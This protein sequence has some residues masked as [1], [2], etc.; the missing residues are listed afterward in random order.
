MREQL[1]VLPGVRA[2][3]E[4]DRG[5]GHQMGD[6]RRQRAVMLLSRGLEQMRQEASRR[7]PSIGVNLH[8]AVDAPLRKSAELI[9]TVAQSTRGI[10]ENRRSRADAACILEMASTVTEWMIGAV[11]DRLALALIGALA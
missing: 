10:S 6:C 8:G 11:T 4:D 2:D 7:M 3:I 5:R 9:N 1:R